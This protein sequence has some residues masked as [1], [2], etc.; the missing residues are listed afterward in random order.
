MKGFH[1]SMHIEFK[2]M[3]ICEVFEVAELYNKLATYIKAKTQDEYF[4]FDSISN[5][6][7]SRQLESIIDDNSKKIYIA[8]NKKTVGFISGEIVNCFLPISKI[9]EVGYVSAA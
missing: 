7:L 8:K 3:E 9:K 2:E 1:M 6:D 5:E 4:V